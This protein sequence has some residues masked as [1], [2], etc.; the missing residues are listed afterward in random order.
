MIPPVGASPAGLLAAHPLAHELGPAGWCA[1]LSSGLLVAWSIWRA[2]RLT[3][4]P[5]E[6]EPD[7]IKRLILQEAPRIVVAVAGDA[8]AHGG[9]AGRAEPEGSETW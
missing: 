2:V 9:A 1:V 4:H 6:E 7:H 8:A 3:V 5:G